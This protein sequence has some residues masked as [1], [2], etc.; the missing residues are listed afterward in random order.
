MIIFFILNFH[1]KATILRVNNSS[2]L[3]TNYQQVDAAIAAASAGDT[4]YVSGSAALYNDFTITKSLTIIGAGTF[5]QKQNAVSSMVNTV[6]FNSNISD[7]T[8]EGFDVDL[9]TFVNKTDIH[10]ITIRNNRINSQIYL[11]LLTNS[12]QFL[13]SSN[14]FE[15]AQIDFLN[16]NNLSYVNIENNLIIG[17]ILGMYVTNGL[18]A[19]NTFYSSANGNAFTNS[20]TNAIISD[21]IFYN[22]EPLNTAVNCTYHN[23]IS[24]NTA[25]ITYPSMGAG[26][27]DN[28]NPLFINLSGT[29]GYIPSDNYHLQTTSPGHNFAGDGTDVGMYGGNS[30][31]TLT[32]ETFNMP[33]IRLLNIQN[34]TVPQ[35]GNV[36]VKV[37][38]TKSRTN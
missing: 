33:V 8:L 23:N 34:A 29:N 11:R 20:I 16:S 6:T 37:R 17:D 22:R 21:N 26:N 5:S 14:V 31:I 15:T 1:A 19:H 36:N 12:D 13:I 32:G 9:I 3:V 18:I 4:I 10:K 27:I 28:T 35:N 2:T 30:N 25:A 38:S 24:Y 7:V